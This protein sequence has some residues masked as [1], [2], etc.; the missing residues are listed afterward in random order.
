MQTASRYLVKV[1]IALGNAD[2]ARKH[3]LECM[4]MTMEAGFVR[5]MVNLT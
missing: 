3:L 2:K 1:N 5:E 4:T